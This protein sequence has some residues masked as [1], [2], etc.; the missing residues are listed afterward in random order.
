MATNFRGCDGREA[1][2]REGDGGRMEPPTI[3]WNN[4]GLRERGGA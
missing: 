1:K 2:G 3:E 4:W